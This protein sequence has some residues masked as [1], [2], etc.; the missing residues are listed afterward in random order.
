[1]IFC[2]PSTP[3]NASVSRIDWMISL[4]L[5]STVRFGSWTRAGSS[6]R[7]RTSCWVHE[8]AAGRR[9]IGRAPALGAEEQAHD[10]VAIE[11]LG[12]AVLL[13]AVLGDDERRPGDIGDLGHLGRSHQS[14]GGAAGGACLTALGTGRCSTRDMGGNLGG[15]FAATGVLV[16]RWQLG[17]CSRATGTPTGDFPMCRNIKTLYNF[18]PPATQDEIRASALQF[19]RKLSAAPIPRRRTKRRSTAPSIR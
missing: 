11:R 15:A 7:W 8:R 9:T 14:S 19:V 17:K 10:V 5:R 6:S 1:M 13:V 18:S 2:L 12:R 4:T 16:L 3:G